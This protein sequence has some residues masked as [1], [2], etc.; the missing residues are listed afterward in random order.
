MK[1]TIIAFLTLISTGL[2]AQEVF[3]D[4]HAEKRTLSGS[5]AAITVSDGIDLYLTQGNEESIA[6]S[7]SDPSY[8]ERF[9]T[10]VEGSVLK[11]Y[12]ENKG[13]NWNSNNKRKLVAYVSFKTLERLKASSGADVH[14]IETITA[15]KLEMEVSSGAHV[16]GAIQAALLTVSESSGAGMQVSGKTSQLK[17]DVSSGSQFRG[18]E[19]EADIC[20]AKASSGAGISISVTKELNAHASSGGNIHYKGEKVIKDLEVNS[21]GSVKKG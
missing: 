12:F 6:V 17:V 2:Q 3:K 18:Y 5:F 14:I 21:G 13:F 9:K 20:D 10:E 1:Q 7:A 8:L 4:D 11:L 19:L 16:K 15:S